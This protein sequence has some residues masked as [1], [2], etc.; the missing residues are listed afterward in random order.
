[1]TA[2][3]LCA[4]PVAHNEWRIQ[5]RSGEMTKMLRSLGLQQCGKAVMGDHMTIWKVT[6]KGGQARRR[7]ERI[8]R[9]NQGTILR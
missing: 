1:M 8:I 7:V 9:R 3:L 5:S 4:W 6:G 2:P